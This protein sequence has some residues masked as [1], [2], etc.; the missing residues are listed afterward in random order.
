[1]FKDIDSVEKIIKSLENIHIN[2]IKD[3]IDKIKKDFQELDNEMKNNKKYKNEDKELISDIIKIL[4]EISKKLLAKDA[5][6]LLDK[7][8]EKKGIF[9]K[10]DKDIFINNTIE[11]LKEIHSYLLIKDI[12]YI[13]K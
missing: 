6:N 8:E 11:S 2:F 4:E 5:K 7:I 3:D 9:K 12:E 10:I 1:M 13:E